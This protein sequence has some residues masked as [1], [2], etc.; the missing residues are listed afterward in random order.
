MFALFLPAIVYAGLPLKIRAADVLRITG[1]QLLGSLL[2]AALGFLLRYWV[3]ADAG[4]LLRALTIGGA[5]VIT[6][7]I[8]V[9]GMFNLRAPL[10]VLARAGRDLVPA[11]PVG[12]AEEHS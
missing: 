10:S 5:Y 1:R 12:I 6:Y 7:L 4:S 3:L 11:R 8:I 9:V 2:A